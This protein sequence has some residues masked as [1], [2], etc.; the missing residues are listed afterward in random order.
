VQ[1][2]NLAGDDEPAIV[3]LVVLPHIIERVHLPS[4]HLRASPPLLVL[5]SSEREGF[6][7]ELYHPF[8]VPEPAA[9][10]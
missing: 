2:T 9:C 3:P 10:C 4:R 6:L 5:Q 1:G 8:S 7:L